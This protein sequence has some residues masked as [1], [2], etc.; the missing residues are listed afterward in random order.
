MKQTIQSLFSFL[1]NPK[2]EKDTD[3]S[4]LNK[5][6]T[7]ALLFCFEVFVMLLL[8]GVINL[9]D[10]SGLVD[11]SG[12]ELEGMMEELPII[13]MLL[14]GVVAVPFLEEL[15]F[16][17]ALKY[18]RNI[19]LRLIANAVGEEKIRD[20]WNKNYRLI[21]YFSALCFGYAHIF[22]FGTLSTS[23]LLFSP[24]LILPQFFMG[25]VAG[26]LRVRFG[27]MWSYALHFCHNL[28]FLGGV[29]LAMNT[30]IEKVN[31]SNDKYDIK[32]EEIA[33]S[34]I[35]ENSRTNSF[36]STSDS[37]ETEIL[38]NYNMDHL[39]TYLLDQKPINLEIQTE[40]IK[41]LKYNIEFTEKVQGV[42]KKDIMLEEFKDA[43]DIE[44]EME[45]RIE[46]IWEL[47]LID[48]ALLLEHIRLDSSRSHGVEG[49]PLTLES[50]FKNYTLKN[51]S[52]SLNKFYDE[53]I[54][55]NINTGE[56][57]DLTLATNDFQKLK[58]ELKNKYGIEF[59]A[60]EK[61]ITYTVIKKVD[62]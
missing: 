34:N 51:I 17:L 23:V 2:D 28:L 44:I 49:N 61:G 45:S 12:H 46:E 33:L 29:F 54:F 1:R 25:S 13:A 57:F 15:I 6:K 31:I 60:S 11:L 26:F 36:G 38:K 47:V 53:N 21:F 7:F 16:R 59:I 40:K 19:P 27:F 20:F 37:L 41:G 32:I 35:K 3:A 39:L 5:L 56:K 52:T 8:V 43:Y 58:D 50:T 42:N 22:N 62:E 48:S 9:L 10:S 24:I 18:E 14:M 30:A 4:L 55:T